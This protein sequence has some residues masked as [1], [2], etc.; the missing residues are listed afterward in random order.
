MGPVTEKI[1]SPTSVNGW[2]GLGVTAFTTVTIEREIL[3]S[4]K[5]LKKILN[6]GISFFINDLIKQ[7]RLLDYSLTV[8]KLYNFI[9]P[10][11]KRGILSYPQNNQSVCLFVGISD[12]FKKRTG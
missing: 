3:K 7:N 12:L 6:L 2:P 11:I 8:A 5:V 1:P 10:Q 4:K 9:V